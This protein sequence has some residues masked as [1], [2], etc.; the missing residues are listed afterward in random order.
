MKNVLAMVTAIVRQ[1]IRAAASLEQAEIAITRRL[2][3]MGRAHDLLLKADWKAAGLGEVVGNA[4]AQH[5]ADARSIHLEGPDIEVCS[6]VILPLT[7]IVN[8]LCTNATK[9]GA[10]SRDGGMVSFTWARDEKAGTLVFVWRE[11]GG[12]AVLPPTAR[13]FGSRLIENA[14]PKQLG[15]SGKLHFEP[16]GIKFELVVPLEMLAVPA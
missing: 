5:D 4:I 7:L 9:Y 13:S 11:S 1:S 2:V 12:P 3:A 6:S 16:S 14:L 8:E 15:G 10:L